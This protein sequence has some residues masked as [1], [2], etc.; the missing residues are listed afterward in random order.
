MD[1]LQPYQVFPNIPEPLTF[2]EQLS[3]NLWWSWKHPAKD[4]FRRIDPGL[5]EKAER[6]PITFL[7]RVSQQ[8]LE[9]LAEDQSFLSHL[10]QVQAHFE[11]RVQTPVESAVLSLNPDETIAY[12]SMEFG[13]HESIPIFAGGLGVLAGDHLKAASNMALPLTGIGLLYR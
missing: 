4:L 7:A 5:W 1:F 6:N 9:E 10:H 12:F 3:R 2:I 8:R 13:L 11:Q